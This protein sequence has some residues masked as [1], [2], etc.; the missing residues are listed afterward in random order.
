MTFLDME[1]GKRETW[2]VAEETF[3]YS[4]RN[5]SGFSLSVPK[6]L[7]APYLLRG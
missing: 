7:K 3:R 5:T 2:K 6:V 1:L 4:V